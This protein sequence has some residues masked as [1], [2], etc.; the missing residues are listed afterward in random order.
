MALNH[1]E[2]LR[3]HGSS[4]G[5][6]KLDVYRFQNDFNDKYLVEVFYYDYNVYAIK[7]FMKKHKLSESRYNLTYP[8]KFKEKRGCK[9]GNSNFLKVMNTVLKI[10]LEISKKDS[11]ASFGFMGA[12]REKELD[13]NLNSENINEDCTI[14]NT[15]RYKVYHLYARRYFNPN[16]FEY[17]DSNTSSILLLRNNR[18]K[19]VLT[20]Q[21]AEDYIVNEII[22]T[23]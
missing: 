10:T 9:T 17:I 6:R 16:D 4:K 18:N 3:C 14:A 21:V 20:K 7:F 2:F 15:K 13:E 23:L 11:L 1:Y 12:P 5:I 19:N 22:P 8:Q